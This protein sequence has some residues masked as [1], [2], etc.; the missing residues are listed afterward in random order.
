MAEKREKRGFKQL[1]GDR[2][3]SPVVT[4]APVRVISATPKAKEMETLALIS[5]LMLTVAGGGLFAGNGLEQMFVEI[6]LYD[7]IDARMWSI[8]TFCVSTFSF[9]TATMIS[10]IL[11]IMFLSSGDAVGGS[12]SDIRNKMGFVWYLPAAYFMFGYLTMV[13]GATCFFLCLVPSHMTWGCLAF[14][15]VFM[16]FPNFLAL[17]RGYGIVNAATQDD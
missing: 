17:C 6:P 1:G 7:T 10:S 5:A 2:G 15:T 9:M 8:I 13:L 14:C 4:G 3:E 16:I 11:M 12:S